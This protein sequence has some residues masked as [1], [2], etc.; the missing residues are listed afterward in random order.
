M[1]GCCV[2]GIQVAS[3]VAIALIETELTL[4]GLSGA[5]TDT[6][7]CRGKERTW[8]LPARQQWP[9]WTSLTTHCYTIP[10]LSHGESGRLRTWESLSGFDPPDLDRPGRLPH[11]PSLSLSLSLSLPLS[12][13]LH[14]DY[15]RLRTGVCVALF[16]RTEFLLSKSLGKT[17]EGSGI[18]D[19]M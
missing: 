15:A 19:P 13:S 10:R 8:I 16:P 14:R 4:T 11:Q 5:V 17:P 7:V 18:L 3:C 9:V 1:N 2:V 6:T 12:L